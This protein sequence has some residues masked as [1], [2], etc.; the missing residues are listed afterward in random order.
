MIKSVI[1][2][3]GCFLISVNMADSAPR[4]RA[5]EIA[6]P[7]WGCVLKS[8]VA[9]AKRI[10]QKYHARFTD[11]LCQDGTKIGACGD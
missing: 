2:A 11:C 6:V 7:R 10:C 5:S 1:L 3:A 4:C 8:E 9:K